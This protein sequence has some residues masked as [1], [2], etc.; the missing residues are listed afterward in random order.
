MIKVVQGLMVLTLV[1]TA[2]G[3]KS[4][5]S[6]DSATSNDLV[7]TWNL[8]CTGE[9]GSYVKGTYVFTSSQVTKSLKLDSDAAC[10][11]QIG[12][13]DMSG[14]SYTIGDALTTPA[15]AKKLDF[16][17][18]GTVLDRTIFKVDG[19]NLTLGTQDETH[20]GT[21]EEK[22]PVALDTKAVYTKS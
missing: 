16:S 10:T 17:I 15:G 21:T 2:C 19:T 14:A 5:S 20:D 13:E 6:S 11:T 18:A 12:N 7:G 8:A 1:L 3:K 22:R 4:D 9:T